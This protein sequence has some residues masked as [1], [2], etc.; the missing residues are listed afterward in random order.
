MRNFAFNI[1]LG[2]ARRC[3]RAD[4]GS[5]RS[6]DVAGVINGLFSRHRRLIPA[7]MPGGEPPNPLKKLSLEMANLGKGERTVAGRATMESVKRRL[8]SNE[9]ALSLL[10]LKVNCGGC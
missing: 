9:A 4:F 1:L 7:S 3:V 6:G 10:V 5:D 8:C 2:A